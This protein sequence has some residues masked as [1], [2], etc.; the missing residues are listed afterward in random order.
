MR[1]NTS[2]LVHDEEDE[3]YIRRPMSSLMT[4]TTPMTS[5]NIT[6][7]SSSDVSGTSTNEKQS[8]NKN[9]SIP[10]AQ[11]F[12]ALPSTNIATNQSRNL[13]LFSLLYLCVNYSSSW[14]Q[15]LD[16]WWDKFVRKIIHN[17]IEKEIEC[18]EQKE[19]YGRNTSNAISA[20]IV[21]HG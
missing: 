1:M 16:S 7:I 10:N 8:K 6:M 9:Q 12:P 5:S 14:I 19:I 18:F 17:T 20:L 11:D 21:F 4:S 15:C 13:V 3:E 2:R